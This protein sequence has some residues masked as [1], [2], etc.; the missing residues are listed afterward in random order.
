MRK[1]QRGEYRTITILSNYHMITFLPCGLLMLCY[2]L[3]IRLCP[4][5]Y[6]KELAVCKRYTLHDFF[7]V[8]RSI[9]LL[10]FYSFF[11]LTMGSR[12]HYYQEGNYVYPVLK[13]M[14][15]YKKALTTWATWVDKNI[16][17]KRT[18]VVFRGYSL[19]HF[20]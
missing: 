2:A 4:Y 15:A 8:V 11:H 16:N 7:L 10:C 5:N 6:R 1:H 12:I 14:E 20:R 19:T 13:V 3:Q 18:Q 9:N 17:S